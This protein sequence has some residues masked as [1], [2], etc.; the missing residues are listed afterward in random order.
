MKK[1]Y[2][3]VPRMHVCNKQTDT[4]QNPIDRPLPVKATIEI[5]GYEIYIFLPWFD[6]RSGHDRFCA[7]VSICLFNFLH[8]A[9]LNF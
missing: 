6:F 8:H 7:S 5:K 2:N 1:N 4:S 3:L 9:S